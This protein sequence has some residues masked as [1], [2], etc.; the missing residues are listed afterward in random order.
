MW[1]E[2]QVKA[3]KAHKCQWCCEPI[4]AGEVY[5][6]QACFGD[7][8]AIAFRLHAECNAAWMLAAQCCQHLHDNDDH[9]PAC[10]PWEYQKRGLV[11][12]DD[13][14]QYITQAQAQ[15]WLGRLQAWTAS[16]GRGPYPLAI[17]S[18]SPSDPPSA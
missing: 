9:C 17:V 7:G 4:P 8:T 3:R 15:E 5:T 6:R 11:Y 10:D 16:R 13:S 2:S 1:A 18:P 12:D 14:Q